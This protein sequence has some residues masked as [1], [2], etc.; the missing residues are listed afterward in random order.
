M[1]PEFAQAPPQPDNAFPA[2]AAAVRVTTVPASKVAVQ[3]P[4]V[5]L[6]MPLGLEVTA[7]APPALNVSMYFATKVGPTRSRMRSIPL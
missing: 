3:V 7:P 1:V 4:P 2:A 5:Q 6:A